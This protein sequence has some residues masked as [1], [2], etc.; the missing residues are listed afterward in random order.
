MSVSKEEL[1]S[2]VKHAVEE[3][4]RGL[5]STEIECTDCGAKFSRVPEY[6]DHRVSEYMTDEIK[7]LQEKLDAFKVPSTEEF[8]T[9]CKDGLC[10]IVEETYNVTKKGE[11]VPPPEEEKEE[12]G[13]FTLEDDKE[14][15]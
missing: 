4:M 10:K 12:P 14:E 2:L 1:G 9:E 8:L 6:L 3:A 5:P 11:E 13:L 7:G 15:E